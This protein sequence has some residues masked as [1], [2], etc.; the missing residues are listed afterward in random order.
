MRVFF[1]HMWMLMSCL[2]NFRVCLTYLRRH[3]ELLVK[4]A[5][6]LVQCHL[7]SGASTIAGSH[8][9]HQILPQRNFLSGRCSVQ[10]LC[11]V[12]W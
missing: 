5:C 10:C 6:V 11:S 2:H 12:C 9:G 3:S 7:D 4:C 8:Q 1:R